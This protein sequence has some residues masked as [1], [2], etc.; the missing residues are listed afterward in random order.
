LNIKTNKN[1]FLYLIHRYLKKYDVNNNNSNSIPMNDNN[2]INENDENKNGEKKK[3]L[4]YFK[5]RTYCGNCGR[6]GHI[7]K[8]C[9]EPITSMGIINIK[10]DPSE[11]ISQNIIDKIV[12]ELKEKVI[13]PK[14]N[15]SIEPL[16][17]KEEDIE[18]FCLY[19]DRI[20]FLLI[21]RKHT[22]GYIEF[23][24]GRYKVDNIDGITFL[25]QQMI[26]TEIQKIGLSDFDTLWTEIWINGRG[27]NRDH[28][29]FQSK[30]KFY[31]LKND[32]NISVNLNHYIN[33]VTPSWN[34]PEW[35]F[36]KGRRNFY[37]SNISCAKREFQEESGFKDSEYLFLEKF[38]P[39]VEDFIGTNGIQYKH[40]YY[41]SY[42]QTDR[43]PAV[44]KENRSQVNEIGDIG[45]FTYEE[46]IKVLRPYHVERIKLLTSLFM[47]LLE[48]TIKHRK[49]ELKKLRT[50]SSTKR[51]HRIEKIR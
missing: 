34:Y 43:L 5:K 33:T 11:N 35:G 30:K 22:L 29:Y 42:A 10:I 15:P 23:I 4:R 32:Q 28:D 41:I 6:T 18:T 19:K 24:R 16:C 20:K 49:N 8:N 21:Q 36:P 3:P 51:H 44:N 37:E 17:E 12:S 1:P 7:Y 39:F 25:F 45:W 40:I 50:M 27:N 46:A 2:L 9:P 47:C 14:L 31:Q 13:R 26:P 38:I 48:K